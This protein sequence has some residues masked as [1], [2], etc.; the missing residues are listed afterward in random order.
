MR[1]ICCFC[2]TFILFSL[3]WVV[4]CDFVIY[5]NIKWEIEKI[6]FYILY[7]PVCM[8]LYIYSLHIL[9]TVVKKCKDENFTCLYTM[10][11]SGVCVLFAAWL[12]VL[13]LALTFIVNI[14]EILELRNIITFGL[15]IAPY[16]VGYIIACFNKDRIL[17][18]KFYKTPAL[19]SDHESSGRSY[20]SQITN[21]SYMSGSPGTIITTNSV[22]GITL[23]K[24]E[25]RE[26]EL[27]ETQDEE[28]VLK[29]DSEYS[30]DSV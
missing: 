16:T 6:I 23:P 28:D 24:N 21:R 15:I 30:L 2:I 17:E 13:F 20:A 5:K 9:K 11:F 1:Y 10:L 8:L 27:T 19:K 7:G 12:T 18:S 26:F 29:S 3:L 22:G 25:V 4:G 14:D